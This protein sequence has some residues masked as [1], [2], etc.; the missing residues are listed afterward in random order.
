MSLSEF[1][2]SRFI[3]SS[4]ENT[5]D[6][7][8]LIKSTAPLPS[9]SPRPALKNA[10]HQETIRTPQVLRDFHRSS[11]YGSRGSLQTSLYN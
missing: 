7:V 4:K 8:S 2:A 1:L 10:V 6:I 9:D 3:I 5:E 11:K